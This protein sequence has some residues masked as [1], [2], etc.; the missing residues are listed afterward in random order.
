MDSAN[1]YSAP[2]ALVD[3]VGPQARGRRT[4]WVWVITLFLGF[5]CVVGTLGTL[6]AFLGSPFGG[7][8]AAAALKHMI[9][10]DHLSAL[11]Q[12]ALSAWAAVELFRM[13]R[14]A[15]PVFGVAFVVGIVYFGASML[16]RPEYRLAYDATSL[17]SIVPGWLAS[18]AIIFYVWRLHAKGNL[19]E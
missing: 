15:L 13:K 12:L 8:Q 7:P 10:L 19:R 2:R 9:A 1:P 3:D 18:L 14:R 11:L 16:L 6:D 17:W 4:V 5:G